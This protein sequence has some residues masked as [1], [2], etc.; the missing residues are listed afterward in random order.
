MPDCFDHDRCSISLWLHADHFQSCS[1]NDRLAVVAHGMIPDN[2]CK[3]RWQDVYSA[4]SSAFSST[5][6]IWV[7]N[8]IE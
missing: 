5:F 1:L 6:T 7:V 2:K 8:K 4:M 3:S